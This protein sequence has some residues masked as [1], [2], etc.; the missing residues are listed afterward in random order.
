MLRESV[1]GCA[2]DAVVAVLLPKKSLSIQVQIDHR[3]GQG[4]SPVLHA[5]RTGRRA[6]S[7][8]AS[9][10]PGQSRMRHLCLLLT[11]IGAY[12]PGCELQVHG[13]RCVVKAPSISSCLDLLPGKFGVLS[14]VA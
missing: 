6:H 2:S 8:I 1:A 5:S 14:R 10:L 7:P 13:Q 3:S 4:D 9:G 12:L 11:A